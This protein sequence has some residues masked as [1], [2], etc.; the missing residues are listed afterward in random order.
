MEYKGPSV[1][2]INQYQGKDGNYSNRQDN[3]FKLFPFTTHKQCPDVFPG[4]FMKIASGLDIKEELSSDNLYSEVIA[5]IEG[6]LYGDG[7]DVTIEV[8]H[9]IIVSS[10]TS[11]SN[12][13]RIAL[14]SKTTNSS[15]KTATYLVSMVDDRNK[16][17]S[18]ARSAIRNSD[19]D[20]N[21]VERVIYKV[22]PIEE[23]KVS[24]E[25]YYFR[26]NNALSGVFSGDLNFVL[27]DPKLT[28]LYLKP[29]LH[30]YFFMT[31]AQNSLTVNKKT[32]GNRDELEELYFA[33]DWEKTNQTRA[34][35]KSGFKKLESALEEMFVHAG[36]LE[37]LN[38]VDDGNS[39][40]P[41]DYIGIRDLIEA[42]P[43]AEEE[44]ATL[45]IQ[46]YKYETELFADSSLEETPVTS[47][48]DEIGYLFDSVKTILF[49]TTRNK[50]RCDYSNSFR[51]FCQ[52]DLCF[53][54]RRGRSGTLLNIT[55][56]TLLLL[57]IL[58]IGSNENISLTD[59]FKEFKR[60]GVS[61]DESS[62]EQVA[63][64][65]EKRSML[66]KK[67]D[68]GETQYVKRVL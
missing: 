55:D 8:L 40:Q 9:E 51:L 56:K 64:Y 53:E 33:L 42:D 54:K 29:L 22:V 59:L 24:E 65:F 26:I 7:K 30:F 39:V 68:S 16:L 48:I 28:E 45:Q 13:L 12:N 50:P 44:I 15:N 20:A 2:A 57:T 67:S 21:V 49:N 25:K 61:L 14:S 3:L 34:C 43:D 38:T 60:R 4:S 18:I 32:R 41:I 37:I 31:V 11:N 62:K 36:V 6:S 35:Y 63:A 23:S 47:A 27:S 17:R 46:A 1:E 10:E 5:L 19:Q 52:S 58:S 66:D